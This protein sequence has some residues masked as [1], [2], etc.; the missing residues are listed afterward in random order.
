MT[1]STT[2]RTHLNDLTSIKRVLPE[3][4][5]VGSENSGGIHFYS[6][7]SGRR[8]GSCDWTD[9]SDPRIYKA[10]VTAI[11]D[12]ADSV[13]AAFDCYHKENCVLT[14]DKSTLK[15]SS[16]FGRQT[17]SSTKT[18]VAG[19]LTY[20]PRS[21]VVL[22]SSVTSSAF[23]YA[24]YVRLWDPRS[25]SIVWE[26]NEP[27]SGRSSRYGDS[28][29]DV[30]VDSEEEIIFKVCSKSGDLAVADLRKLGQDPW[31]YLVDKNTSLRNNGSGG[32]NNSVMHCYRKQ[33]F[34]GRNG[35]LEVWSRVVEREGNTERE[36][37]FSEESYRRN[38]VDKV[39]D[40]ERGVINKIEGG[41]DRLF[42]SREGIEGI[43]VWET[44]RLS[45][46][47]SVS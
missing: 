29:A 44:S 4:A 46:A 7:A 21:G 15:V 30:A 12:S 19:K 43:E 34:V 2:I 5:A 6:L 17:G 9:K 3:I 28:F 14:I 38:Y 27:G 33:V 35:E 47:V 20:L 10:R 32:G 41:G 40:S 42:V 8:V 11:A 25:G 39:E 31:V 36:C 1:H 18:T 26:T 45:G 37:R 16:E 13:F 23:G 22:G 24:G